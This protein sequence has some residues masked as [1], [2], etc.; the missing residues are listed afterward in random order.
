MGLTRCVDGLPE[1]SS[2]LEEKGGQVQGQGG[3]DA[4]D[5]KHCEAS[6]VG[7]LLRHS[8]HVGG[9]E[10]PQDRRGVEQPTARPP[11]TP[12]S[13]P[14]R[15]DRA[16]RHHQKSIGV[17]GDPE[18]EGGPNA[19]SLGRQGVCREGASGFSCPRRVPVVLGVGAAVP[20]SRRMVTPR[21]RCRRRAVACKPSA[22]RIRM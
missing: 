20:S 4:E 2:V 15:P 14:G 1:A 16:S 13:R 22:W 3:K 18:G 6:P 7:C 19:W 21:E 17:G 5:A 8:V 12:T 11:R 10:Q 9:L